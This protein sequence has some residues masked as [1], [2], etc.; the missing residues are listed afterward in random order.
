M[1]IFTPIL[2]VFYL[3]V[4]PPPPPPT[5]H[6]G[7]DYWSGTT[8]FTDGKPFTWK[9]YLLS[10]V[11]EPKWSTKNRLKGI[12]AIGGFENIREIVFA[13]E[14][15]MIYGLNEW[16]WRLVLEYSQP[17][18]HLNARACAEARKINFLKPWLFTKFCSSPS[19]PLPKE[20]IF[21]SVL[22]FLLIFY[23]HNRKEFS[24]PRLSKNK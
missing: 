20:L 17:D 18:S 12:D 13:I 24:N 10:Y 1:N 16:E 14:N 21:F 6:G 7:G 19:A 23:F 4:M 5:M 8:R 11:L 2:F 22:S 3:Q 15:K 9:P